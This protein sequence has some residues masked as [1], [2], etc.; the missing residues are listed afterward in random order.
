VE[1]FHRRYPGKP[2]PLENALGGPRAYG[3]D[4]VTAQ[5]NPRILRDNGGRSLMVSKELCYG[6]A[7]MLEDVEEAVRGWW[8]NLER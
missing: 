1:E 5:K 8:Y 2:G 7:E 4:T 6:K 3:G